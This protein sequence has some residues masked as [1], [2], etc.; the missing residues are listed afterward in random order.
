MA[1]RGHIACVAGGRL[2]ENFC[3]LNAAARKIVN[4]VDNLESMERVD[5]S[6]KQVK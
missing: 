2:P 5:I 3:F 6:K 4:T 1:F